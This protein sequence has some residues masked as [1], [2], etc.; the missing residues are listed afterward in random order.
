[1]FW[2]FP[3]LQVDFQEKTTDVIIALNSSNHENII[4]ENPVQCTGSVEIWLN[5]LLKE[6]QDTMRSLLAG[7]AVSLH[8]ADFNFAEEFPSFCGQAGI[9]GVQLLWTRDAEYALRKCRTDKSIMKRTNTKFLNLLNHF[10]DL[11]VKDLTAL[12]RIRFE[13]MVTIHVHQRWVLQ[14]SCMVEKRLFDSL[15]FQR[16]LR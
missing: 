11:T 14:S 2:Y 1:M 12:D 15:Q 9:I 13:T 10:I 5:R 7:M 16:Y 4:L 6:M 3:S 8:D